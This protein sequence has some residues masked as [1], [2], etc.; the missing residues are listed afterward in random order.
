MKATPKYLGEQQF[1]ILNL[2][3]KYE[4]SENRVNLAK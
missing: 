3:I 4:S 2:L 1:S